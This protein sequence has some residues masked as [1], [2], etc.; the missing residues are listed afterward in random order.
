M[1]ELKL[2]IP[3][4]QTAANPTPISSQANTPPKTETQSNSLADLVTVKTKAKDTVK[5]V[6]DEKTLTLTV[7][8]S[9]KTI[10]E[11]KNNA[12]RAALEQAFGAFISSKTEI[13]ND[14]VVKDEIVS[15]TNGNIQKYELISEVEIPKNG[16][17]IT[18]RATV[19]ID[20]LTIFAE[21]KGVVVEF[22]GGLFAQNIKLQ[23]INE[24]NELNAC[25]NL[26]GIVHELLQNGFDYTVKT[27][28]KP[29]LVKGDIWSLKF[30]VQA[31]PNANFTKA[32]EYLANSLKKLEMSA[33]EQAAYK[34]I[35]KD[36]YNYK[37]YML[38]NELSKTT[39]KK[40]DRDYNYYLSNFK[41]N[42]DDTKT[43]YGPDFGFVMDNIGH[44]QKQPSFV[45][46]EYNVPKYEYFLLQYIYPEDQERQDLLKN[47]KV[48]EIYS[49]FESLYYKKQDSLYK[50]VWEQQ[51]T[52]NEIGEMK[53]ISIA[54][55]GVRSK[56]KYGGFVLYE[57]PD[58]MIVAAPYNYS[59][60]VD[61]PRSPESL[62]FRV[63]AGIKTS[64]NLFEGKN[65][66]TLLKNSTFF[67]VI[68]IFNT[69][70]NTDWHIATLK[71]L[72]L[73]LKEVYGNLQG[74]NFWSSTMASDGARDNYIG[75]W[76]ENRISLIDNDPKGEKFRSVIEGGKPFNSYEAIDILS[77]L[78][79]SVMEM[80]QLFYRDT[81]IYFPLVKYVSLK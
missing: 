4:E 44:L 73:Y 1:E 14:A 79:F 36:Y 64:P 18:I 39:L 66:M 59:Y 30:D 26:F 65:N 53:K 72:Q 60:Y 17:G 20:K 33:D 21:S 47:D 77:T 13:L 58:R 67:D 49:N 6:S 81:R 80:G 31:K 3:E 24:Q 8:G 19:S 46:K 40:L 12:L 29:T 76:D 62:R 28:E 41:I 68:S 37:G 54:G 16:Y 34:E 74:I 43:I 48:I 9:G 75:V 42:I 61:D 22:K 7:T 10:E 57:D 70:N 2:K 51:F 71:E 27:A 78:Y 52:L 38:R 15:V 56:F 11:A 35:N 23:K 63:A 55:R 69:Q 5:V 50:Y 25:I 45:R 32:R